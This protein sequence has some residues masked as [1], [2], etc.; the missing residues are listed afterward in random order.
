[1]SNIILIVFITVTLQL[2]V[3][4]SLLEKQKSVF[5]IAMASICCF[6]AG[7]LYGLS[8]NLIEAAV[9]PLQIWQPQRLNSMHIMSGP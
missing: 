7:M 2:T 5:L 1:M 3:A 6:A 4:H 9:A 8:V